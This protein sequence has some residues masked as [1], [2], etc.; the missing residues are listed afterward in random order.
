MWNNFNKATQL[1]NNA[2]E[3]INSKLM[4]LVQVVHTNPALLL[5]NLCLVLSTAETELITLQ[6]NCVAK[7]TIQLIVS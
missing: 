3:A 2:N 1:T 6:E 7:N 4:K 5:A